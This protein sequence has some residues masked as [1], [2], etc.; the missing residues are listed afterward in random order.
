MKETRERER[1]DIE[2]EWWGRERKKENA[3]KWETLCNWIIKR[4]KIRV[5]KERKKT[6]DKENKRERKRERKEMKEKEWDTFRGRY[7]NQ[8][9][10]KR[11]RK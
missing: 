2:T 4:S 11:E 7:V 3:F 8:N 10:D 9:R 1:G 5:E 6:R